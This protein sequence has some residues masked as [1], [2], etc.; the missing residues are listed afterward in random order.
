MAKQEMP[1]KSREWCFQGK[2][3][4]KQCA[5]CKRNIHRY[6]FPKSGTFTVCIL[7]KKQIESAA[8]GMCPKYLDDTELRKAHQLRKKRG[9]RM[10]QTKCQGCWFV[11]FGERSKA[12]IP[13]CNNSNAPAFGNICPGDGCELHSAIA[14]RAA[15]A[16]RPQQT[17]GAPWQRMEAAIN[18]CSK[19]IP[20]ADELW[21]Q[22][23]SE[24][25]A[26]HEDYDF[27]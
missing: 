18:A 22:Y 14:K 19:R 21:E 2:L 24:Q 25:R 4:R 6:Q 8:N 9:E 11:K 13:Y 3:E 16:R 20:T 7:S 15:E 23:E 27:E 1:K 26:D 10:Q 17:G 12:A 5:W